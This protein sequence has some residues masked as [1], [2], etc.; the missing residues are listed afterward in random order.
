MFTGIIQTLGRIAEQDA[1]GGDRRL[2][3]AAPTW[4]GIHL[5]TGESI[6]ING[7]CLTAT[8]WDGQAFAVD[9]SQETLGLTTL[10]TRRVGDPVNL[11]RSLTPTTR[12]GGHLVAGHVDGMGQ[13]VQRYSEGRSVRFQF[14]APAALARYIASKGS[15]AIDG[16]SLTVNEVDGNRFGVNII[17]YTLGVTNLQDATVGTPVNLEVDLIARYLERLITAEGGDW[18]ARDDTTPGGLTA[19][20]LRQAGFG[21]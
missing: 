12:M 21:S 11:E 9:V 10:G 3:I 14:E 19:E 17:P 7:V 2:R 5:E 8:E 16:I 18:S 20:H 1:T 4:A 15:I 6:A 13:V